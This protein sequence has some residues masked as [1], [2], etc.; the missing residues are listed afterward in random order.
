MHLRLERVKQFCEVAAYVCAVLFLLTK[1]VGGQLN[2]G[3]EIS[4]EVSRAPDLHSP[5][6]DS[7]SVLVKLKRADIGRLE[8]LDVLIEV[9][10]LGEQGGQPTLIRNRHTIAERRTERGSITATESDH[11]T[12]L[13]PGDGTQLAYLARVKA[14][15]PVLID[16]TILAKRTGLW[17]GR[18]QWRASAISLPR[19]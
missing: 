4:L 9:S 13:P 10:H 8:I 14:G 18:P 15:E 7:L 12:F 6:T 1:L 16:V 5:R 19:L 17:I 11:G 3:T 2:A